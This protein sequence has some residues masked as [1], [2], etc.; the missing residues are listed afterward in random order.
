M[1]DAMQETDFLRENQRVL[2]DI[3]YVI[4]RVFTNVLADRLRRTT[5]DLLTFKGRGIKIW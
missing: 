5:D 4:Y 2:N 3:R 1:G